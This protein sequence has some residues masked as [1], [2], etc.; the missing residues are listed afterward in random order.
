MRLAPTTSLLAVIDVQER[1]LAAMPDAERVVS[2]CVRLA[3]AATLLGVERVLTEQYPKG[4]GP[5]PVALTMVLPTPAAKLA[6][7][8]RGCGGF[9]AAV[10]PSL[11]G[12]VLAG[13]ETHVC[14]AQTAL[15]LLADG[16]SVF[17]AV[18]AVASRHAIDHETALRRL[19]A[20]GAVLT[21]SEAVLFEW[22]RSADHPQFQHV[23]RLVL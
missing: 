2:R 16:L 22:C 5:T 6:F 4:L 15:D 9:D 13:L 12:V 11:T 10:G 20:A 1:L 3:Q 8:C 7:S 21:T 23:R 17:I 14:I 18:D 19:E